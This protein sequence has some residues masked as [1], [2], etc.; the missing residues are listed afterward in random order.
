MDTEKY[1]EQSETLRSLRL[2]KGLLGTRRE[3]AKSE[4]IVR[5]KDTHI[6]LRHTEFFKEWKKKHP[7]GGTFPR[8]EFEKSQRPKSGWDAE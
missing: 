5:K 1:K 2:G 7:E 8:E 3:K 4:A 6:P